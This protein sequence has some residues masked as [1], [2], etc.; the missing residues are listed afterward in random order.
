MDILVD[1]LEARQSGWGARAAADRDRLSPE[2][3][4]RPPSDPHR[5]TRFP[6]QLQPALFQM[7]K[8]TQPL[9]RDRTVHV[10]GK[11]SG[12]RRLG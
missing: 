12:L 7:R 9:D 10:R 1:V 4:L 8:Q 11:G 5:A 2:P 6:A 3:F